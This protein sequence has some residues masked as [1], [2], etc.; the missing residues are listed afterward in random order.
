[1]AEFVLELKNIGKTFSGVNV[2]R[3]IDLQLR[4]GEVLALMGENGAGKSTL[5]KVISGYHKP[6]EGGEIRVDGKP[7]S[8]NKPKDAMN[9]HI[10]TIYQELTL[11]PDMSSPKTS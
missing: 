3:G 4:A 8:F 2:L 7:V 5:I 10:H 1:M 11:C 6:D 9:A